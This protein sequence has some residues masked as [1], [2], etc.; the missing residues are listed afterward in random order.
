MLYRAYNDRCLL[1]C[2]DNP[3]H[4]TEDLLL[5]I[6]ATRGGAVACASEQQLAKPIAE[7]HLRNALGINQALSYGEES[8]LESC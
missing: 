1:C 4:V 3:E 5:S 6:F 8:E 2:E 7:T